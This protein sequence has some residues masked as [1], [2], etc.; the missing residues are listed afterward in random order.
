MSEK[1]GIHQRLGVAREIEKIRGSRI[2]PFIDAGKR[3]LQQLRPQFPLGG[4]IRRQLQ[5]RCHPRKQSAHR[6][7]VRGRFSILL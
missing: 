6:L 1:G 5:P 2:G 4:V 7:E 3:E